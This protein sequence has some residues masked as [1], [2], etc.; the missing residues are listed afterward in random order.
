MQPKSW[1]NITL[2]PTKF[3]QLE[4]FRKKFSGTYMYVSS[5]KLKEKRLIK[6]IDVNIHGGRIYA[7]DAVKE[8]DYSFLYDSNIELSYAFPNAKLIN[9]ENNFAYF[10]RHPARQYYKAPTTGNCSIYFP[11]FK[12]YYNFVDALVE[13]YAPTYYSFDQ[14]YE[15]LKTKQYLGRAID[16]QHALSI[17]P[18][19]D[20]VFWF[21]YIDTVIATIENEKLILKHEV[22]RQEV[23]DFLFRNRI[24]KWKLN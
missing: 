19:S 12:S 3:E 17:A 15:L 9:L 16:T 4:E 23:E 18:H 7:N 22:F 13:A 11:L 21:W 2:L 24:T 1:E 5:N 6:I 20:D 14:A 8:I 10:S